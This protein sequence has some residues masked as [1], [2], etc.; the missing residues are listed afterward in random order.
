MLS[1]ITY[2]SP[3][4]FTMAATTRNMHSEAYA[5]PRQNADAGGEVGRS[6]WGRSIIRGKAVLTWMCVQAVLKAGRIGLGPRG[7]REPAQR[8]QRRS[9]RLWRAM[10]EVSV[11]GAARRTIFFRNTRQSTARI[12]RTVRKC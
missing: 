10:V 1:G 2:G 8:L 7:R 4:T 9:R 12:D 6:S 3:R 5:V 11:S